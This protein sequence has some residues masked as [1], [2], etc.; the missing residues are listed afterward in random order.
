MLRTS[1]PSISISS[2]PSSGAASMRRL[3]TMASHGLPYSLIKPSVDQ[4]S[5][6]FKTLFGCWGRAPTRSFTARSSSK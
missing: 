3:S 5:E 2:R 1:V 6:Y 4:V